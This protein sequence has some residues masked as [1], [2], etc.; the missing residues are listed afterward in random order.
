MV[1][2][3]GIV[4]FKKLIES[5]IGFITPEFISLYYRLIFGRKYDKNLKL[6]STTLIKDIKIFLKNILKLEKEYKIKL[7]NLVPEE[8]KLV[9]IVIKIVDGRSKTIDDDVIME[10]FKEAVQSE[11]IPEEFYK[12]YFYREEITIDF[13]HT[14]SNGYHAKKELLN[15]ILNY[16]MLKGF[17]EDGYKDAKS[18]TDYKES[19]NGIIK[20][21]FSQITTFKSEE[22]KMLFLSEQ[23]VLDMK[24][25]ED[26]K[27]RIKTRYK[28]M[29]YAFNGGFENGRLYVLGGISGGGK[30]TV[31]CNLAYTSKITLD[32]EA[33]LSADDP[34]KPKNAVL[35]LTLENSESETR[36]RFMSLSLGI[37]KHILKSSKFSAKYEEFDSQYI[38]LF[39]DSR[40]AD[41]VVVW[42]KANSMSSLDVMSLINNIEDEYN[43]KIQIVFI[44]YADKLNTVDTHRSDQEWITLGKVFDDLKNMAVELDIPVVTVTQVNKEGYKQAARGVNM[45]GS[46]RKRENA[47]VVIMYD[48]NQKEEKTDDGK[49]ILKSI[50]DIMGNEQTCLGFIP[51]EGI[52]DKNRDGISG[53]SFTV[54]I[55][56]S[57]YRV[58]DDLNNIKEFYN[59]K[60]YSKGVSKQYQLIEKNPEPSHNSSE[61]ENEIFCEFF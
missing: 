37:S 33:F 14:V 61:L 48:F 35:Y 21:C 27:R 54:Y 29:D 1:K 20:E 24:K 53:A 9:D 40:S 58:I 34:D 15:S 50:E 45:A 56:Y 30:S 17:I 4:E 18:I 25:D 60:F 2:I 39:K 11:S 59:P 36:D 12:H 5:D 51:I 44:D 52:I 26:D 41:I 47:D 57:T 31:M 13:F 22:S 43:K 3:D 55:E 10:K 38:D 46:M 32:E 16:Y 19:F 7:Y 49:P 28:S 23:S 6:K 42:K 8:K